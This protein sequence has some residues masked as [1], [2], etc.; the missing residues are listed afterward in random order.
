VLGVDGVATS[1][2]CTAASTWGAI[3]ASKDPHLRA[4]LPFHRS[5][6]K[7]SFVALNTFVIKMQVPDPDPQ[8][9]TAL[10]HPTPLPLPGYCRARVK[11]LKT[12][13]RHSIEMLPVEF[14]ELLWFNCYAYALGVS[15]EK[16]YLDLAQQYKRSG[17]IDSKFVTDLISRGELAEV[18]VAEVRPNDVVLYFDG[19]QLRHAG[20]VASVDPQIIVWSKWGT[21]ELYSH[22]LWEVPSEYGDCVRY[23]KS[24]SSALILER[25]E[26]ALAAKPEAS[27]DEGVWIFLPPAPDLKRLETP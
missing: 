17:L 13:F 24:P 4:R 14:P 2:C 23:F 1:T 18:Q 9:R 16:R 15:K 25:L 19:D 22:P 3:L 20:W 7:V 11:A 27:G 26:T 21:N 8:L 6:S 5:R 12:N 10:D